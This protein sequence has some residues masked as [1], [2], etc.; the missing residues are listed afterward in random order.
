MSHNLSSCN[1]PKARKRYVSLS[2]TSFVGWT[3]H[4]VVFTVACKSD[5]KIQA[6][7]QT[8]ETVVRTQRHLLHAHKFPMF[9]VVW[10]WQG[11]CRDLDPHWSM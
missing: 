1:T 5:S 3:A 9:S 8:E 7:L 4:Q 6:A 2:V 10:N 11:F